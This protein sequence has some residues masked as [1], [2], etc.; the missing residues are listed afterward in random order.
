MGPYSAN[1]CKG[2]TRPPE[3]SGH[4]GPVTRQRYGLKPAQRAELRQRLREME[5]P[6]ANPALGDKMQNHKHHEPGRPGDSGLD[7]Q[8]HDRDSQDTGVPGRGHYRD[9]KT[10]KMGPHSKMR[11]SAGKREGRQALEATRKPDGRGSHGNARGFVWLIRN[12]K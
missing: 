6:G 3:E 8:R 1:K 5:I 9:T 4:T 7:E 12:T 10:V 2:Q 11:N